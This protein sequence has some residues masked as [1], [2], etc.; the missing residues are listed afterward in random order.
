MLAAILSANLA[1]TAVDEAQS[2]GV[3]EFPKRRRRKPFVMVFNEVTA[4]KM[5]RI[6]KQTSS[7]KVTI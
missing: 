5:T 2:L 7:W 6:S 4:R 1:Q 3:L